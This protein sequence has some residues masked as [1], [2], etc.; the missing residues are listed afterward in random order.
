MVMA[1]S[2]TLIFLIGYRGSGKSTVARLLADRLE[3]DWLDADAVLEHRYGKSIREIFANEGEDGFRNKETAIL[4]ELCRCANHVVATGGG[5]ILRPENR[6]RLK[7]G[8]VVWLTAD[9]Q[10][11]WQRISSDSGTVDRRPNLTCG[12]VDEVR[13]LLNV[14]ERLYRQS[15]DLIVS[16]D[17]R[18]PAQAAELIL[19]RLGK[20]M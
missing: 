17:G 12:G 1:P 9:P 3:W 8:F 10:T 16:T 5:V 19:E 18:T 15:A 20:P 11:L 7:A 13:Q 6:A 14:R 4:D 2:H